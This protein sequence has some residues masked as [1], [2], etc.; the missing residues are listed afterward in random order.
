M[1]NRMM[2]GSPRRTLLIGSALA[3]M[4]AGAGI[5]T[6]QPAVDNPPGATFQSEGNRESEGIRPQPSVH[7]RTRHSPEI[8]NPSRK[9]KASAQASTSRR[10]TKK[11][12]T[13]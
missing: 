1:S 5:A 11:H 8:G 13:H 9:S 10:H 6:A 4:L 12:Q 3:A 2:K 7:S